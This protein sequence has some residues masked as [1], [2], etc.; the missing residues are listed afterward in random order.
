[1][2]HVINDHIR[3]HLERQNILNPAQHG[4]LKRHSCESQLFLTT[5]DILRRLDKKDHVHMAVLDFSKAFDVVPHKRLLKK[6]RH[7]GVA[8]KTLA[9]VQE[10]LSGRTQSV[11][12]DGVRS[13]GRADDKDT[14][15]DGDHVKSGVPQGTVL[16]PLCFLMFIND[17]PEVTSPGTAVRLFAD[18]CLLYRSVK[19]QDDA[20]ILQKDLDAVYDWGIK[21]GMRFNVSKCNMLMVARAR[22]PGVSHVRFYSMNGEPIRPVQEAKYLGVTLAHDLRWDSH[23]RGVEAKAARTL[24]FLKRNLKGAPFHLRALAYT[25]MVQST[26]D[27]AAA[28]WDPHEKTKSSLLERVHNRAAR[29]ACRERGR[30]AATIRTLQ[31][32][33]GWTTLEERRRRQRLTLVWRVLKGELAV[34]PADVGLL[35]AARPNRGP[36]PNPWKLERQRGADKCSPLWRSTSMRTVEDFNKL[37][38]KLVTGA[39]DAGTFSKRLAT[40][41]CP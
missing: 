8:G 35:P 39:E 25:S 27:Y 37:P 22:T 5:E 17:L 32:R 33:L 41:T 13:H 7:Y 30:E 40:E 21:W 11:V 18:D 4:F 20:A 38:G 6:M 16:G 14:A 34:E 26:M 15:T 28:I 10:F 31:E 2:E 3:S 36:D 24:G 9:W 23:I 29:W 19:D 12:V 1:M